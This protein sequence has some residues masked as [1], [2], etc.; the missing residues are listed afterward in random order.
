MEGTLEPLQPYEYPNVADDA[1][2]YTSTAD[3][4]RRNN[5]NGWKPNTSQYVW[6]TY[7]NTLEKWLLIPDK[8]TT[9]EMQAKAKR[10]VKPLIN[11]T[12]QLI[13]VLTDPNDPQRYAQVFDKTRSAT[14]FYFAR[15]L[16]KDIN[17]QL[18]DN[19][20][21]N[22]KVKPST[23]TNTKPK[24]HIAIT[25]LRS[26]LTYYIRTYDYTTRTWNLLPFTIM[27]TRTGAKIIGTDI[28]TQHC[29]RCNK[30]RKHLNAFHSLSIPFWIKEETSH[31]YP[32]PRS[33]S[34]FQVIHC[35]SCDPVIKITK[36]ST[37]AVNLYKLMSSG[38]SPA[39][40][41]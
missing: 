34:K 13:A 15:T 30:T 23:Q 17:Q 22:R 9:R 32:V 39:F 36:T 25:K 35:L 38:E 16:Y 19:Y 1:F 4:V 26:N 40:V 41:L 21:K 6:D 2:L 28:L 18:E 33:A 3:A 10:L 7:I 31:I 29:A 20:N 37:K 8:I 5:T 27:H 14:W 12:E 11:I 24:D